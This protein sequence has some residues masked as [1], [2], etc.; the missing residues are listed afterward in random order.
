MQCRVVETE[1]PQPTV[2][3]RDSIDAAPRV[4]FSTDI[5]RHAPVQRSI[6][7]T[8]DGNNGGGAGTDG[9]RRRPGTPDL[10]I[11]T[12]DA[13]VGDSSV[14]SRGH[15]QSSSSLSPTS[16]RSTGR[17]TPLSPT[18]RARGYSLRSALFRRNIDEQPSPGSSIELE[19]QAGSSQPHQVDGPRDNK[20]QSSKNED[21][22]ITV[23]QLTP[24]ISPPKIGRAHV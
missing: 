9:S 11:N 22:A 2:M 3:S 15:L 18:S 23:S 7:T 20:S 1:T 14:A 4:R 16:P 8:G 21:S 5:E 10:S 24:E 19:E 17:F 12:Q 6:S 13:V